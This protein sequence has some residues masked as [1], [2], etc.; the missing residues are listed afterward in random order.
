[1]RHTECHFLFFF[2]LQGSAAAETP[3]A[4]RRDIKTTAA[5]GGDYEKLN[6]RPLPRRE[7]IRHKMEAAV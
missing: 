7:A 4:V 3:S 6:K 1:M 2:F 5:E